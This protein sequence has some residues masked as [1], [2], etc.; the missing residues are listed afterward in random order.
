M[1][2]EYVLTDDCNLLCTH[3][4]RGTKGI[5]QMPY[6]VAVKG[7]RKLINYFED[8]G[9]VL[10]GGEP[11]LYYKFENILDFLIENKK[12]KIGLCSNGT[13]DFFLLNKFE[14]YKNSDLF[15][16]ISID[17]DRVHN[18]Q[19]RG[20]GTFDIAL[21]TVER[22]VNH[23]FRVSVSTTITSSNI[24]SI[25]DLNK[26]LENLNIPCWKLSPIMPY[27][28]ARNWKGY[29]SI[30]KWNNFAKDIIKKTKIPLSIKTMYDFDYLDTISDEKLTEFENYVKKHH[31]CNCGSGPN[32]LYV[33][34]D[35]TVYPCTCAIMAF[36]FG[37]LIEDSIEKIMSC[38]NAEKIINYTL[39]GDSPCKKCRYFKLCNG[40]C[41]GISYQEFGELGIGDVRCT[42]FRELAIDT[43]YN[44]KFKG[45]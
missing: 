12:S 28:R 22:L 26:C 8:L 34:P 33:Y 3:C 30:E 35:M 1:N 37:N 16:Q 44:L 13:T 23:G 5:S 19:I 14:K 27:G 20:Q 39:K 6:S 7:L 29:V 15:F 43:K 10:T 31:T 36:P 4:I 40:G 24:D 41:K 25:Y 9:I 42:R 38:K 18:D 2:V 32:R 21:K 11:T 17:G 45:S